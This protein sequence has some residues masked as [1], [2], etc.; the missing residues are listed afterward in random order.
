MCIICHYKHDN[1]LVSRDTRRAEHPDGLYHCIRAGSAL[2]FT[3]ID[4]RIETDS[5]NHVCD[6]IPVAD[7][8]MPREGTHK[9]REELYKLMRET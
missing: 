5:H 4:C 1:Q 7:K 3:C 9:R 2:R 6:H 8:R